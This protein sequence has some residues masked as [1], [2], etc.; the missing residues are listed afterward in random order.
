MT[1]ET[2]KGWIIETAPA[3]Q[4]S[5]TASDEATKEAYLANMTG[6]KPERIALFKENGNVLASGITSTTVE[7][8]KAQIDQMVK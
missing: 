6:G 5:I 7:K 4:I 2:Y 3:G 1:Q 8:V